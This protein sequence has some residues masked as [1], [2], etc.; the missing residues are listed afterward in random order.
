MADFVA[1]LKK[2]IGNLG[3]NTPEMREKVYAKARATIESKLAAISPPPPAAV[4]EKQRKLLEDAI[5]TIETEYAPLE[6]MVEAPAGVEEDF[7]SVLAQLDEPAPAPQPT[8]APEAP[9]AADKRPAEDPVFSDILPVSKPTLAERAPFR[10]K[11]ERAEPREDITVDEPSDADSRDD[12]DLV[13]NDRGAVADRP[14]RRIPVMAVAAVVALLVLA[15]G[16][17][18]L[19]SSGGAMMAALG[20]GG[21]E[22]AVTATEA[23]QPVEEAAAPEE[24]PA[25]AEEQRVAAAEPDDAGPVS[26]G[27][28]AEGS[29]KFTQRLLPGGDE[30]DEGPAGDKPSVG[31]GTSVASA[32]TTPPGEERA[33]AAGAEGGDKQPATAGGEQQVAVGQKAIYYEERTNVADG[34]AAT[35]SAVWSLVQES[36]GGDLPPEPAIRAEI[37]VP[38]RDVNMRLTIR[39][40]GDPTLPASHIV[41]MIFLTP[42]N[43]EGG[44]IDNVL[45]IAFKESEEKAGSPL[46]GIP[47]KIADGFFLIALSDV[48]EEARQNITVMRNQN[49]IDIPIVYRSGRRALVTFDKGI[50]GEKVFDEA[51]K[52]WEAASS[53]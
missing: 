53:G 2:T 32:T 46:L 15:G 16:A 1:V 22:P 27:V 21:D 19:W 33:P 3:E 11:S 31:E 50:P 6:E 39:R 51:L 5:L 25:A 34:S 30:V 42:E 13:A 37:S 8:A 52:A 12:G 40:N 38:D 47:A 7:D 20:L 10:P 45:R 41:E 23:E 28:A 44:G 17:Y 26:D 48:T 14:A 49:W 29:D 4:A 43:F 35:G 18:A 9:P 24:E 36:P